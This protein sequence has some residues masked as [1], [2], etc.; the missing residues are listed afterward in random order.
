MV[1]E[2][3]ITLVRDVYNFAF[4]SLFYIMSLVES[5]LL[6]SE[7]SSKISLF[8]LD[9]YAINKLSGTVPQYH[10]IYYP[11]QIQYLTKNYEVYI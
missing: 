9:Y 5:F 1:S 10:K 4:S 2:N 6:K 3:L 8:F 11:I 7:F